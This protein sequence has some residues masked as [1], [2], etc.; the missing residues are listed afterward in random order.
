MNQGDGVG[1]PKCK[2]KKM[3]LE[4]RPLGPKCKPRKMDQELR[5]PGPFCIIGWISDYEIQVSE[6]ASLRI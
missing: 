3:D 1:S 2:P 6:K 5:P 4:L